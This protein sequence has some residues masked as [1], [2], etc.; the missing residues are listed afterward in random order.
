M[1]IYQ[2][3]CLMQDHNKHDL[4]D[5]LPSHGRR[6]G[7]VEAGPLQRG[8]GDQAAPHRGLCPLRECLW[9]VFGGKMNKLGMS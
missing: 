2:S 5:Q 6:K 7:E 9:A 3:I 1:L 4:I 8:E